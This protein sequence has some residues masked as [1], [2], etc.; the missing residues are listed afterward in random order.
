[1][2]PALESLYVHTRSDDETLQS[3]GQWGILQRQALPWLMLQARGPSFGN[4]PL[5]KQYPTLSNDVVIWNNMI[6]LHVNGKQGTIKCYFSEQMRRRQ[7]SLS[8]L[9][10]SISTQ[11]CFSCVG[12]SMTMWRW[13]NT[14]HEY[15]KMLRD[16]WYYQASLFTCGMQLEIHSTNTKNPKPKDVLKL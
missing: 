4:A 16:M 11:S 3:P 1:M 14:F 15:L 5:L 12:V 2:N 13:E 10:G 7:V 9:S 8:L 6:L